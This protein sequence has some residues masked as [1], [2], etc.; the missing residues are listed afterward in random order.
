MAKSKRRCTGFKPSRT[1]GIARPRMT[2]MAYSMYDLVISARRSVPTTP[3]SCTGTVERV[4]TG[5]VG[6]I[7]SLV[8]L[9]SALGGGG[10]AFVDMAVRRTR[11]A[12]WW[13]GRRGERADTN[14]GGEDMKRELWWRKT[15][16]DAMNAERRA[17]IMA[18]VAGSDVGAGGIFVGRGKEEARGDWISGGGRWRRSIHGWRGG[19]GYVVGARGGGRPISCGWAPWGGGQLFDPAGM[20]PR[21]I[22]HR[23]GNESGEDFR[24]RTVIGWRG[25]C[26]ILCHIGSRYLTR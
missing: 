23:A 2:D 1:S 4:L 15:G 24:Q 6:L 12:A 21:E 8:L 13:T 20:R 26:D 9:G 22:R 17:E 10:S 19:R 18:T 16:D 11:G 5:G 7:A 25:I 3:G 14:V